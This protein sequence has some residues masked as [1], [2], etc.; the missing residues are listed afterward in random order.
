MLQPSDLFPGFPQ[1]H[2]GMSFNDARRAVER[3]G[4]RGVGSNPAK[5]ELAWDIAYKS[6]KGRGTVLFKEGTGAYEIAVVVYAFDQRR[7]IFDEWKKQITER[8]GAANEVDNRVST[9][10]L[11]RL[12]NGFTLELR[13]VKDDD[14][15]V[16]EIHWVKG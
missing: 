15:P 3:T 11:W 8:H 10:E 1:I 16:V 6:L 9:S 12:K 7:A 5:T 2:W 13:L 14:S 4:L